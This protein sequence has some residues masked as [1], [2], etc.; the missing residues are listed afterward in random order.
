MIH[1]IKK[2]DSGE[3]LH[4]EYEQAERSWEDAQEDK[5]NSDRE[6]PESDDELT[7]ED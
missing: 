4:D 1:P 6:N 7:D 2:F 3:L 5:F